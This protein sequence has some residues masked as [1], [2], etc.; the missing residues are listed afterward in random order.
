[1]TA[2]NPTLTLPEILFPTSTCTTSGFVGVVKRRNGAVWADGAAGEIPICF[3]A[4]HTD[5]FA[6]PAAFVVLP[7]IP[8]RNFLVL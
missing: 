3:L 7:G 4:V 5:L 8:A 1:M 6:R 2:S